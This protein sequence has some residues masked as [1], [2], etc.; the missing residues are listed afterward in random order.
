MALGLPIPSHPILG[1]HGL[2]AEVVLV[3]LDRDLNLNP[4]DLSF[5]L[6]LCPAPFVPSLYLYSQSGWI[7]PERWLRDTKPNMAHVFNLGKQREYWQLRVISYLRPPEN[8]GPS[9]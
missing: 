3:D 8:F 9:G 5:S 6:H 1:S 7:P 4:G 2:E